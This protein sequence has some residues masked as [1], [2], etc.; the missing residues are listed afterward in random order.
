MGLL[1]IFFHSTYLLISAG[2]LAWAGGKAAGTV[3]R[4]QTTNQAFTYQMFAA[5]TPSCN[6]ANSCLHVGHNT[7]TLAWNW[8]GINCTTAR[9]YVC[10]F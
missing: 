8:C 3:W 7:A 4:W 2:D 9:K 1:E 6:V 10:E 5:N